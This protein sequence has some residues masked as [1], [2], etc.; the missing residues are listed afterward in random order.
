[1]NNNLKELFIAY[2]LLVKIEDKTDAI[3]KSIESIELEILNLM[4]N[5]TP[6]LEPTIDISNILNEYNGGQLLIKLIDA[7][8]VKKSTILNEIGMG[9]SNANYLNKFLNSEKPIT[10]RYANKFSAWF[11]SK[12]Y[13]VPVN[14]FLQ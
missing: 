1:M 6:N 9:S 4:N 7:I 12:G 11:L 8:G 5:Q 10:K 2:S 13:N 14:L 3:K